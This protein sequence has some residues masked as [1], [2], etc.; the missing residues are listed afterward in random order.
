MQDLASACGMSP[1]NLYRFYDGKLAIG[2]AV[3]E[4]EQATLLFACDRAVRA[5]GPETVDRLIALFE[6]TIDSTRRRIRRAP[7]LFELS[8]I[9]AR[10]KPAVRQDFLKAVEHRIS[11]I[12]AEGHP[13]T[14]F[15][16]A[17]INLHS[18]LILMACAPFVLPWMM[19]NE[20]FGNP[21]SMVE[22]LVRSLFAGLD[23]WPPTPHRPSPIESNP[24]TT[25][26]RRRSV[27][28]TRA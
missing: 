6:A 11:A 25:V 21:R 13:R 7:R 8:L 16:S 23:D 19:Q 22:P 9:V 10:E 5:A 18:H 27:I 3:A 17:A 26:H 14:A 1:A 28:E 24:V 2:A 12:L 4:A 15:E 20:P